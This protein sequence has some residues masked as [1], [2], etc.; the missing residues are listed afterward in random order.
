MKK[1]L[2]E[3]TVQKTRPPKKGSLEIFDLGYPGLAL[4]IG[5]G[6]SKSFEM[7]YRTGG[8]LRRETLGR[9]PSVT[10]AQA[11][12][13]WRRT[14]EAIAKGETPARNGKGELFERVVEEWLRRDQSDNRPSSQYQLHL[15]VERDLLPAWSGRP[16]DAIGKRDVVAVLDAIVD[17]GAPVQ[18]RQTHAY[19]KRFFKWAHSRDLVTSNPV[20][21]MEMLGKAKSRDRVLTN[22]E[23]VKVWRAAS[24]P[25]GAVVKL[26]ALTGARREEIAQLRWSEIDGSTIRLE[27]ERTKNGEPHLIYLSSPAL[28][29][30]DTLART[31]SEFVF[32]ANNTKHVGSWNRAKSALDEAAGVTGWRIHDL[33]RT[34]STGLNELGVDPHIVESILGH[35]VKGVAGVYNRA[36]YE[37]AKKAA[38]D[39]WGAHVSALIHST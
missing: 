27:G 10:L 34:I 18:A 3:I 9:W 21:A 32:T 24:G 39:L 22:E 33:R 25:H 8:K 13:A 16:I 6:G 4:R 7:F 31:N 15:I 26:L 23:L 38:L 20:A 19:L 12:D 5:H 1:H 2:T 28:A 35:T 36:K 17:R 37:S 30:L 14:R 11:R 29:V